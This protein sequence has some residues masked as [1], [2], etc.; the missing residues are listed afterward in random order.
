M[1]RPLII[2]IIHCVLVVSIIIIVGRPSRVG[3]TEGLYQ[4]RENAERVVVRVELLEGES[5]ATFNLFTL[6]GTARCMWNNEYRYIYTIL[7]Y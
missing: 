7:R 3:F 2:I 4:V 5:E 6:D 1:N